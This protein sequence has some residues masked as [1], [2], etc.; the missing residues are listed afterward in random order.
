MIEGYLCRYPRLAAVEEL[1]QK[2]KWLL[3][4][5]GAGRECGALGGCWLLLLSKCCAS[6]C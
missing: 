5:V 3:Q 1:A 6:G 4:Q 2:L